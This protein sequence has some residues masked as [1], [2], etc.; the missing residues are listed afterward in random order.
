MG[1]LFAEGEYEFIVVDAEER[2]SGNGNLMI[3]VELEV[4]DDNGNTRMVK[5]Y[6]SAKR[7]KKLKSAAVACGI[8]DKFETGSL[9]DADFV[10][11]RG[12]LRLTIESDNN[13]E[14][15]TRTSWMAPA[16][17]QAMGTQIIQGVGVSSVHSPSSLVIDWVAHR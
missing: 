4:S 14:Y 1:S 9:T 6:L 7:Q 3:E 10:D 17:C 11:R 16:F 12:R 2:L 5:D 13:G 8:G 15:P